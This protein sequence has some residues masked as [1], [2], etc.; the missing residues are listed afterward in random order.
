MWKYRMEWLLGLLML[1]AVALVAGKGF[2]AVVASEEPAAPYVVVIDA[3]HGGQDPGKVGVNQALEKEIN[4][5]IARK[6]QTVLE[7]AGV[8]VYMTREDDNGLYAEADSNKKRADMAARVA[9]V[10]EKQP[11]LLISIHQNSYPSESVTGP[12][13]FYYKGSAEGERLAQAV[14]AALLRAFPEHHRQAKANSDYYLLLHTSCPAVIAECGF[15]SNWKEAEL[16]GTEGYQE[17]MAQA[18]AEGIM[19][20]R[21][22]GALQEEGLSQKTVDTS[23]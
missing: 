1:T 23:Q 7:E 14:Q 13:T 2:E 4:L 5:A 18:I 21:K 20:Y 22:G 9:F 6:L 19:R 11:D 17:Q 12:Q 15:L 10:E 3:G 8:T 16:L